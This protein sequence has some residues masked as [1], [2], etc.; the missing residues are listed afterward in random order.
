[1]KSLTQHIKENLFDQETINYKINKWFE[2]DS[3][4]LRRFNDFIG[5]V[6]TKH[7][8]DKTDLGNFYTSMSNAPKFIDF[9]CD[10][11]EFGDTQRD[12]LDSFYNVVRFC[13]DV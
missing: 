6:K 10:N 3:E 11:T 9:I 12:Y 5:S 8:V 7:I 2:R 1:M 13:A 4:G